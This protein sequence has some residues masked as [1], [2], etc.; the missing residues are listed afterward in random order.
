MSLLSATEARTLGYL[1]AHVIKGISLTCLQVCYSSF[2][3]LYS[4][5]EAGILPYNRM[6]LALFGKHLLSIS[7]IIIS[8]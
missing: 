2:H 8:S 3:V 4:G 7:K 6:S 1:D 5:S